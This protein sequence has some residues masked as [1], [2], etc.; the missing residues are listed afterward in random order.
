MKYIFIIT[1]ISLLIVVFLL[2]RVITFKPRNIEN[3]PF[4][5]IGEYWQ[6]DSSIDDDDPWKKP[7]PVFKIIDIK[8][9]YA[10]QEF[11]SG[12]RTS[13]RVSDLVKYYKRVLINN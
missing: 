3:L 12:M 9:G 1:I 7:Y 13:I 6:Y 4:P 5:K 10:L 2:Y 8:S 11:K